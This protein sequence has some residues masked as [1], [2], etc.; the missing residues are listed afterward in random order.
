MPVSLSYAQITTHVLNEVLRQLDATAQLDA[1][2]T[3]LGRARACGAFDLWRRL[4]NDLLAERDPVAL[5][6]QYDEAR[7][8][9]MLGLPR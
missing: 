8:R 1:N 5:L 6:Y 3:E 2:K 9:A 7:L 4:V